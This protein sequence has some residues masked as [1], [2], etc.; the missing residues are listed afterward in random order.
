MRGGDS[1]GS[2]KK[3]SQT[4]LEPIALAGNSQYAV[5]LAGPAVAPE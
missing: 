3:R 1:G 5:T 4:R 2:E